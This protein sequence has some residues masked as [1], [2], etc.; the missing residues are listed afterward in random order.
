MKPL[1]LAPTGEE[2]TV[3]KINAGRKL[4]RRLRDMGLIPD[5]QVRVV[6]NDSKGPLIVAVAEDSRLALGH[7]MAHRI[8][9]SDS[10]PKY[11]S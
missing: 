6:K 8:L 3:Q 2:V 10:G 11:S 4:T 5:A 7:G 1:S 9:V